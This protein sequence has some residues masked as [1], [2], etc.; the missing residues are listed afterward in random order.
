M[1]YGAQQAAVSAAAASVDVL[2]R[3][4]GDGHGVLYIS[5]YIGVHGDGV[6]WLVRRGGGLIARSCIQ[7]RRRHSSSPPTPSI[8]YRIRDCCSHSAS[9]LTH[10]CAPI[11]MGGS[12]GRE[13]SWINY[14]LKC[15]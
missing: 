10:V 1:V 11:H 2:S 3:C 13:Q 7:W 6:A 9:N 12:E 14:F 5:Y 8:F 4:H 15:I